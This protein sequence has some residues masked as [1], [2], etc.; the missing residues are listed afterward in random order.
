MKDWPKVVSADHVEAHSVW[1]K[2]D[3]ASNSKPV[4]RLHFSH[5]N[6]L[7]IGTRTKLGTVNK[8]GA[9]VVGELCDDGV[10]MY[11]ATIF[12]GA[13]EYDHRNEGKVVET[14]TFATIENV[15]GLEKI[16]RRIF[17]KIATDL[18]IKADEDGEGAINL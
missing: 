14:E 7:H 6:D 15:V 8:Y 1:Q 9:C 16:S 2:D 12:T 5:P 17:E 18:N 11:T 10:M 13:I 3:R 4:Y